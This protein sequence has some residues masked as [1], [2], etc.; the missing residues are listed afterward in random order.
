[1][2]ACVHCARPEASSGR[3]DP[4]P[5]HQIDVRQ[6]GSGATRR[7]ASA[8]ATRPTLASAR[9]DAAF[10][11]LNGAFGLRLRRRESRP[12]DRGW[13][14][15][16]PSLR[17]Q[18]RTKRRAPR[19]CAP[20]ADAAVAASRAMPSSE[21]EV[22]CCRP[23]RFATAPGTVM[24]RGNAMSAPCPSIRSTVLICLSSYRTKRNCYPLFI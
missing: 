13:H 10:A 23:S 5:S 22:F 21:N 9:P 6:G 14:P 16:L 17:P 11:R 3:L 7:I 1:M 4:V 12:G 20:A 18:P 2:P 15:S 8:A 24:P 19:G